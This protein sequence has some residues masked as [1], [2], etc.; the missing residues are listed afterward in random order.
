MSSLVLLSF[1]SCLIKSKQ[2]ECYVINEVLK[3]KCVFSIAGNFKGFVTVSQKGV[4]KKKKVL[5]VWRQCASLGTVLTATAGNHLFPE[6]PCNVPV[7]YKQGM[8]RLLCFEREEG[9]QICYLC[10]L[11]IFLGKLE[12]KRC[13]LNSRGVKQKGCVE[14]L[15]R[16]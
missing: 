8:M 2:N 11:P 1:V 6:L 7:M 4:K 9:N 16:P 10:A 5:T 12:Q 3:K 13:C 14:T 15:Q